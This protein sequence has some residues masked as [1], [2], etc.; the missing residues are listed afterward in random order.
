MHTVDTL[1][2]LQSQRILMIPSFLFLK[3]VFFLVNS[4]DGVVLTDK[5]LVK[6]L[7]HIT[8]F[9]LLKINYF[10]RVR[11][12]LYDIYHTIWSTKCCLRRRSRS[13]SIIW[14]WFWS[15]E[16]MTLLMDWQ[17]WSNFLKRNFRDCEDCIES[18][19]MD[20]I[21]ISPSNCSYIDIYRDW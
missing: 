6:C 14:C 17:T 11:K 8:I 13:E 7:E 9:S 20:A 4:F 2:L 10:K 21:A 1:L 19:G 18:G 5:G 3:G 12:Q 15:W 16:S